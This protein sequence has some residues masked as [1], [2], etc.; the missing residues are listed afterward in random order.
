MGCRQKVDVDV[1]RREWCPYYI[2]IFRTSIG[3]EIVT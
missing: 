3:L 1:R 2:V